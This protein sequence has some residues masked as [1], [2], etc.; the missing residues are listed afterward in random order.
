MPLEPGIKRVTAPVKRQYLLESKRWSSGRRVRHQPNMGKPERKQSEAAAGAG[1]LSLGP[2][3]AKP[4]KAGSS[5]ANPKQQLL[6]YP[7]S[8]GAAGLT[9]ISSLKQLLSA[10]LAELDATVTQSGA[11]VRDQLDK[12]EAALETAAKGHQAAAQQVRF[13]TQSLHVGMHASALLPKRQDQQATYSMLSLC[14]KGYSGRQ[15]MHNSSSSRCCG[16]QLPQLLTQQSTPAA[17]RQLHC[18]HVELGW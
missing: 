10:K 12:A 4:G 8:T 1:K 3:I 13:L 2:L 16:D 6:A 18:M 14:M 17:I 5:A 15:G 7:N 11:R 9:N